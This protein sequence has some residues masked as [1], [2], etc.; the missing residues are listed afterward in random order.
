MKNPQCACFEYVGDNPY[1]PVHGKAKSHQAKSQSKRLKT[2]RQKD[3]ARGL[4]ALPRLS[5]ERQAELADMGS[6]G[7]ET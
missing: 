6:E 4:G 7:A 5:K 2:R 1:C 3:I